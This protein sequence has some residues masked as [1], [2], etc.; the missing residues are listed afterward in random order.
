MIKYT[1][2]QIEELDKYYKHPRNLVDLFE[3]TAAKWGDRNAIGT[4]NLQTRQYE[5]ITYKF[6]AQ[7]INNARSGINQLGINKGDAV[8]V[9]IGNS[10][11]WY[12]L[13][14]AA[15]GLGAIFVP[16]YE[17]ELLKYLAIHHKRQPDKISFC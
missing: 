6:L 2:K 16:M 13:E 3:D 4:K 9:I 17:K 11:D 1:E 5:W 14:N 8:G 10:V 12:V 7:R 15:H